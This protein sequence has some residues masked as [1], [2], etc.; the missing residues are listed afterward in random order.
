MVTKDRTVVALIG[1]IVGWFL[2]WFVADAQH[3]TRLE[4][5]RADHEQRL[6][7]INTQKHMNVLNNYRVMNCRSVM[8]SGGDGLAIP[9]V[10][11]VNELRPIP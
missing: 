4:I 2:A 9:G 8:F 1:F 6:E 7:F 3:K 5:V 10:Q 11:C